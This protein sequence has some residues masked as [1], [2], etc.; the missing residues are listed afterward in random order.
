[1]NAWKAKIL[2]D[3][4]THGK[5]RFCET[6]EFVCIHK[7]IDGGEAWEAIAAH[8]GQRVQ[9]ATRVLPHKARLVRG[10]VETLR[11]RRPVY[12]R[13]LPPRYEQ[14]R[15]NLAVQAQ[16]GWQM[17]VIGSCLQTEQH[18]V[19]SVTCDGFVRSSPHRQ[20]PATA[21]SRPAQRPRGSAQLTRAT[22]GV[23]RL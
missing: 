6:C 1:M 19:C 14:R 10:A 13:D 5:E 8:R 15:S 3:T 16:P 2:V 9:A 20:E 21:C 7:Q 11:S 22:E 12:G 17:A 18:P 4:A 23:S